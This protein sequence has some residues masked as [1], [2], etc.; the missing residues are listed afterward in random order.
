MTPPTAFRILRIRPI[1]QLNG[2]MEGIASLQSKCTACGDESKMSNG[3]GLEEADG[4]VR[5][6]CLGCKA[7]EILTLEV[8][9]GHWREQTRRDRILA[10]AGIVPDDLKRP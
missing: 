5:L 1:L 8:A 2:T 7:T 6:T 4:G 10:L 9:L 3:C